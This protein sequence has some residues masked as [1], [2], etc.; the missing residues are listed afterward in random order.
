M[1]DEQK[2]YG[3]AQ[4]ILGKDDIVRA[5]AGRNNWVFF[6]DDCVLTIPKDLRVKSYGIRVAAMQFLS[7]NG[8]PTTKVVKYSPEKIKYPFE[9]LIITVSYTHLT[10]PTIYS[11]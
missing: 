4:R 6:S 8:I 3:Y 5:Q 7:E 9:Y 10:L 1:L 11:V 2:I